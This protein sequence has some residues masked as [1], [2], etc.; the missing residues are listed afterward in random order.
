M[1]HRDQKRDALTK[2]FVK[3]AA[4]KFSQLFLFKCT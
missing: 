3:A 2:N 4:A 1:M